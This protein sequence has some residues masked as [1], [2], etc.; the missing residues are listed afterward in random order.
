MQ[1]VFPGSINSEIESFDQPVN[2]TDKTCKEIIDH[3]KSMYG[4]P[5]NAQLLKYFRRC[6][7]L[8]TDKWDNSNAHAVITDR[9]SGN[10]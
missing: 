10:N 2:G 7:K 1:Y 5:S 3:V 9:A 4:T 8:L 6:L